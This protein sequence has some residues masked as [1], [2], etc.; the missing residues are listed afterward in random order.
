MEI[1]YSILAQRQTLS[2]EGNV[3]SIIGIIEELTF[4]GPG[5]PENETVTAPFEGVFTALLDA[6]DNFER[7]ETFPAEFWI[8]TP[9]G[10]AKKIPLSVEFHGKSRTRI[11]VGLNS[12]PLAESGTYSFCIQIGS[13]FSKWNVAVKIVSEKP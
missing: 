8:E 11:V 7:T 6:D 4:R 5:V 3:A 13:L 9:K 12:L 1:R 10:V 2:P